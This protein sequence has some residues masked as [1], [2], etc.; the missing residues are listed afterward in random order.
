M[1]YGEVVEK[2]VNN[3]KSAIDKN[4]K[5]YLHFAKRYEF[6]NYTDLVNDSF[7]SIWNKV[8]KGELLIESELHAHNIIN[9]A[10]W[11]EIINGKHTNNSKELLVD[12]VDTYDAFEY[13]ENDI[14]TMRK[15]WEIFEELVPDKSK[16]KVV[17]DYADKVNLNKS[18]VGG[19][20]KQNHD[21]RKLT[22]RTLIRIKNKL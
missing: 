15:I 22:R 1:T 18:V 2:G 21:A 20:S 14:K 9:K 19:G 13:D 10:I 4:Y 7:I 3:L 16:Q 8:N 11:W 5:R 6:N 12:V 17:I